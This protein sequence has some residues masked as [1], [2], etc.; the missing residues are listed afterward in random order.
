MQ[1]SKFCD[2]QI[3]PVEISAATPLP[4]DQILATPVN[5]NPYDPFQILAFTSTYS[6]YFRGPLLKE[7]MMNS[8]PKFMK[9]SL[10]RA[11]LQNPYSSC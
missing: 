5:Q 1:N 7:L 9:D 10:N 6:D 4:N 3:Y 2:F 8:S 11:P